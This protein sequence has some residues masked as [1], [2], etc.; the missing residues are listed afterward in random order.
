MGD[1]AHGRAFLLFGKAEQGDKPSLAEGLTVLQSVLAVRRG[2][3]S[4]WWPSTAA[5]GH[6][7]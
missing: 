1:V 4:A 6:V 7:P 3:D 2:A 5:A